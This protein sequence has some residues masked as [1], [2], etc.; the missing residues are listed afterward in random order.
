MSLNKVLITGSSGGLGIHL[1]K[2]FANKGHE[3]ILHGR[4]KEKLESLKINIIRSGNKAEYIIADLNNE[5][6]LANLCEYSSSENVKILINNAGIICPNLSFSKITD[7]IIDSMIVVNLIAPIKIINKL[8][9]NLKYVVNINSMVGIE[10]KKNRTLYA[11]S[12]WGLRGFSNSLKMEDNPY[13]ILDVYP[14]NIKTWP[15]RENAM[16]VNVVV[17][18]IYDSMISNEEEL[19]LD[20]RVNDY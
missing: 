6:D 5:K 3:I 17:N 20:G 14:T 8:S 13:N 10:A 16:D 11:A 1:A 4:D 2:F 12:K 9:G 18:K 19:I 7:D 15:E